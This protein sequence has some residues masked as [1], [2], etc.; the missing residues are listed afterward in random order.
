MARFTPQRL[1]PGG[2]EPPTHFIA[3]WI[4]RRASGDTKEKKI[5]HCSCQESNH[6]SLYLICGLV[7]ILPTLP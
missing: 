2:K 6:C 3:R 7:T 1:C 4:A 5:I